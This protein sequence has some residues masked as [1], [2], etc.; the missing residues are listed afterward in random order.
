MDGMTASEV[1]VQPLAGTLG[2]EVPGID[3]SSATEAVFK[4]IHDAFLEYQVLVY[5]DL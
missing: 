2:A 4:T 5:Y 1:E 3:L